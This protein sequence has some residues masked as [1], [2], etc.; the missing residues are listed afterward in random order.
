MRA[1]ANSPVHR[2]RVSRLAAML[3]LRRSAPLAAAVALAAAVGGC[4]SSNDL[5]QDIPAANAEGLV[6]SL[7]T[8]L[9]DCQQGD[10][11]GAQSQ[12]AQYERAVSQLPDSVDA[13]VRKVLEE[14]ANNLTNLA[15]SKTGCSA[16][17]SGTSGL[18]GFQP[19]TTTTTTQDVTTAP[20]TTT[21]ETTTTTPPAATPASQPAGNGQ[22]S[23]G[24]GN[25]QGSGGAG[26][27]QGSGGGPPE[28]GPPTGGGTGPGGGVSPGKGKLRERVG[29]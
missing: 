20:P 25:G 1:G 27:G 2:D 22:G 13:N 14:T 12:A 28:G 17:A 24:T 6:K 21:T 10:P 19:D 15:G 18:Q 26:N 7:N 8:V 29:S 23:G 9:A 11:A 4:G 5:P 16:G 3:T